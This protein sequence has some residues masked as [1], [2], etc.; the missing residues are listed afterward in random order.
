LEKRRT[1]S[2]EFRV[3][4]AENNPIQSKKDIP[5]CEKLFR[6][7]VEVVNMGDMGHTALL[8]NPDKYVESLEPALA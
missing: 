7:A 6:H 1:L 4:S 3:L 5:R 8:F 2:R